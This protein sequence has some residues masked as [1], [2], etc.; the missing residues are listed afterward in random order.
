MDAPLGL[1]KHCVIDPV[2]E[3]VKATVNQEIREEG[4]AHFAIDRNHEYVACYDGA[5]ISLHVSSQPVNKGKQ[6]RR[7]RNHHSTLDNPP[8]TWQ[9]P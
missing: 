4:T 6:S 5:D 1:Y 3:L 2:Q 7:L 8:N 9:I